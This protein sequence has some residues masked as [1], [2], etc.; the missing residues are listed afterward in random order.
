MLVISVAIVI[1]N[2]LFGSKSSMSD[3]RINA[4]GLLKETLLFPKMEPKVIISISN[5]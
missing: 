4:P 1:E 5:I 2:N 3:I